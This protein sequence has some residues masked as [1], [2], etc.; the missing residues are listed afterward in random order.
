MGPE[1]SEL[2]EL[3]RVIL[4]TISKSG[5][6]ADAI[7]RFMGIDELKNYFQ[8]TDKTELKEAV[9]KLLEINYLR[10]H[11]RVYI[12]TPF[13]EDFL[14]NPTPRL[15]AKS[16]QN[17][18]ELNS[19]E[20]NILRY[21]HEEEQK[22]GSR[23]KNRAKKLAREFIAINPEFNEGEISDAINIL[24]YQKY[25]DKK[26]Q[27]LPAL[28][29]RG[30]GKTGPASSRKTEHIVLSGKALLYLNN[31]SQRTVNAEV[32]DRG[33]PYK[34]RRKLEEV[35][36]SAKKQIIIADN[37]VGRKTLDY[38]QVGN[39][40]VR[41]L[42]SSTKERGFDSALDDF[43]NEYP[44]SINIQTADGKFHGRFIIID[45]GKYYT[46]D[47]SIKDFGSKPS[48]IIEIVDN[49]VQEAYKKIINDNWKAG[50]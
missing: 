40:P 19:L 32:F 38:L 34:T 11:N 26:I 27:Q 8:G 2:S 48:T 12:L 4:S 35:F 10:K 14:A 43:R 23:Y 41:I 1:L 15:I 47:H 17:K 20:S 3:A 22:R 28:K 44:H 36:E 42:T 37:Y 29:N 50:A 9:S 18:Y 30:S 33:T 6:R 21:F 45:S 49:P 25:F 13:G 46:L 24:I 31:R 7:G 16:H 39:A 5:Q